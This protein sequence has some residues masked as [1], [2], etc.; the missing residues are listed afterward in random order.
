MSDKYLDAA[1]LFDEESIE[2]ANNNVN[3]EN[4][5]TIGWVNFLWDIVSKSVM[6]YHKFLSNIIAPRLLHLISYDSDDFYGVLDPYLEESKQSLIYKLSIEDV[7]PHLILLTPL[8]DIMNTQYEVLDSRWNRRK[9]KSDKKNQYTLQQFYS[10]IT[11]VYGLD[12]KDDIFKQKIIFIFPISNSHYNNKISEL[13]E[14]KEKILLD[15]RELFNDR[16]LINDQYL[17]SLENVSIHLNG[18]TF[19]Q[20]FIGKPGLGIQ[21]DEYPGFLTIVLDLV[22]INEKGLRPGG[23]EMIKAQRRFTKK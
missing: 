15:I 22:Y 17:V 7:E 3:I 18:I 11:L 20:N 14:F 2:L 13:Y 12:E 21:M 6:K 19:A 4:S 16:F 1:S 9:F 23:E 10:P 5:K 8:E